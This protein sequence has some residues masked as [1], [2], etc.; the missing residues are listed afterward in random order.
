LRVSGFEFQRPAG[1]QH[2]AASKSA[3]A[4][5][6][7]A[8]GKPSARRLANSFPADAWPDAGR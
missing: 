4:G 7:A 3:R 6:S 1:A 5:V 8:L 2:W